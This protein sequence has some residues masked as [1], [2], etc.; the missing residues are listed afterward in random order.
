MTVVREFRVEDIAQVVAL[1]GRVFGVSR[2]RPP[3]ALAAYFEEILFKNPWRDASLPSLVSAKNGHISGF[4][5][6]V[7]RPMALR[8]RSLRAA[9]CTQ[10]MV[11][12]QH[13]IDLAAIQ[14]LKAFFSGPQDLSL[15]DGAN[16]QARR[17]WIALGGA[18]PLLYSLHWLR[19]LRPARYLLSLLEQRTI[20][21]SWARMG[22]SL[23]TLAD[24]AIARLPVNALQED[25]DIAEEPLQAPAMFAH[26]PETMSGT[27]LQ[28]TYNV[29]ALGWL[30]DQAA[31]KTR[32]GRLRASAVLDRQRRLIGWY[33]YYARA[34]DVSEVIQLA[35]RGGWF[36]RV[37]QRLVL[38]AWRNGATAVRGR[39]DPRFVQELSDHH[40]WFRRD[41]NW[42]LIHSR[43]ADIA[44]AI[45]QGDAFLTRLE[46]EWWLR[47]LGE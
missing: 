14:L 26:L 18:A 20:F 10:F 4:L 24:A 12:P 3:Q 32:H 11:D 31:R 29:H 23:A 42:T 47:F 37:L 21:R 5:G 16:D 7:P 34:G 44:A 1:H 19:P 13:R 46:G 33:L 41:S 9:V 2:T 28:P 45:Q 17:M 6:V 25:G 30:L 22:R 40:C 36:N 35:A 43:H 27:A 15:A 38:D 8:G 39:L